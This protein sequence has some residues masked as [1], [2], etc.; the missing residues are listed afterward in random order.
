MIIKKNRMIYL[1]KAI[2]LSLFLVIDLSA[3]SSVWK[4]TK[5]DGSYIYV[6]GTVHLL[7]KDDFPLKSEFDEAYYNSDD[8]IFETDVS[9]FKNLELSKFI[10]EEIMYKNGKSIKDFLTK[11]TYE[12]LKIYLKSKKLPLYLLK[13]KPGFLISH[14][15]MIIYSEEGMNLPGVDKYFEKKAK[16]Q[17]KEIFYLEEAKEQIEYI[18]NMGRGNEENFIKYNLSEMGKASKQIALIKK[19]WINGDIELIEKE[20]MYDF[21]LKFPKTY[22]ELFVKRN[23]NWMPK[24]EKMFISKDIE[25]VLV[26]FLHLVG[27]DSI[28]YKLK[29]LGYK[30][31][32]I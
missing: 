15:S 3:E 18:S 32:K 29:K 4:V 24:I 25:Y 26:G 11:K 13:M 20:I 23:K 19:S 10:Q 1:F 31:E 6:A 9:K 28:L 12:S 30:I 2:I 22:E 8:I 21:K 7:S 27:E 17:N 14:L 16:K 5:K